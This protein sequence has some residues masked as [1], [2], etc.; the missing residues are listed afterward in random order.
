VE[1]DVV[2]STGSPPGRYDTRSNVSHNKVEKRYAY[3]IAVLT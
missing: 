1:A 2:L 3:E